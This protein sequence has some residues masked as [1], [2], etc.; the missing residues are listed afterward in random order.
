MDD[1]YLDQK[2]D[3]QKAL[4]YLKK[5]LEKAPESQEKEGARKLVDE[6]SKKL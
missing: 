1:L 2:N 3:P 5:Y 6:L 4:Y